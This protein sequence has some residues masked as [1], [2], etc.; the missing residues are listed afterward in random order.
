MKKKNPIIL[1]ELQPKSAQGYLRLCKYVEGI[2][3]RGAVAVV[4]Y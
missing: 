4:K 2:H 3:I 1:P